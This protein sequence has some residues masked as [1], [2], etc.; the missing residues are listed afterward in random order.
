MSVGL[1]TDYFV[2]NAVFPGAANTLLSFS[3]TLTTTGIDFYG[4]ITG[5]LAEKILLPS[6]RLYRCYPDVFWWFDQFV[7][8]LGMDAFRRGTRNRPGL[9]LYTGSKSRDSDTLLPT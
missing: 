2:S 7:C 6:G 9:F 8:R 3:A 5:M 4:P 1:F